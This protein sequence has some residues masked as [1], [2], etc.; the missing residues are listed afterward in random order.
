MINLP[1]TVKRVLEGVEGGDNLA[2]QYQAEFV[3]ERFALTEMGQRAILQILAVKYE[4]LLSARA[5][6][7]ND[8]ERAHLLV[9]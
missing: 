8:K 6:E 3:N 7:L 1:N 9:D 5:K 2:E 4:E